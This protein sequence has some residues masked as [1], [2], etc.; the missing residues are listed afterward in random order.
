MK[1]GKIYRHTYTGTNAPLIKIL[2]TSMIK[3]RGKEGRKE[4]EKERGRKE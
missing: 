2:A 4:D 3:Y 1:L